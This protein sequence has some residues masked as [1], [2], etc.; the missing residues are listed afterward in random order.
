M[1]QLF[2]RIE[3]FGGRKRGRPKDIV[4][5]DSIQN[6]FKL[7]ATE[8]ETLKI[9]TKLPISKNQVRID[10]GELQLI[11]IN[12]LQNSIYW[13]STIKN[14]DERNIEV[15]IRKSADSLSIIFSDSGP[16]IKQEHQNLIFDPY[17][18]T[19]EDGI[20][21]G[22]TIVGELVT[23]YDGDFCLIDNGPLDGATFEVTFKKRI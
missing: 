8:L 21:L 3:P 7:Y 13:L 10:D 4:I 19:R 22:L 1:A 12:L 15:Q 2:K 23:E 6:V 5:E 9:K 18:S 11:V 16:G 20:G 14:V 17:F